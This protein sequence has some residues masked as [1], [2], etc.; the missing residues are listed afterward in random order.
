M[1]IFDYAMAPNPI[2]LRIYC[3][4]KGLQIPFEQVDF[5]KGEHRYSGFLQKNP[6]G[7]VP[8]LE[9][10]NGTYLTGSLV[11]MEYLEECFP[12]PCMIGQTSQER[13]A[14][15]QAERF[16]EWN[17]FYPVAQIFFHTQPIFH[18]R[19]QIPAIA[20]AARVKLPAALTLLDQTLGNHPFVITDKPTIA[21]C[22]LFAAC[23]HA[24]RVD[25]D[26][27]DGCAGIAQWY[28]R[29]SQR[30]NAKCFTV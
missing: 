20:D 11:I 6:S 2:K 12:E 5:K 1:R 27:G 9:L 3:A 19:P 4:E 18:D 10:D 24:R 25:I 29:F 30:P 23:I 17:I 28:Q 14:T 13:A 15:R 8:I 16:I 26:L 7:T 21:D 22:T